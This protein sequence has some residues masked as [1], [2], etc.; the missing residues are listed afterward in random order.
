[1]SRPYREG[2]T[3]PECEEETDVKVYPFVRGYRSGQYE[4]NYP[5]EGGYVE[6]EDCPHCGCEGAFNYE[7]TSEAD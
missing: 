6:P 4:D 1:M 2:M 7:D 5:D 3:C